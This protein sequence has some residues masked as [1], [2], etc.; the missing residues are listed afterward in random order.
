MD[1]CCALC[2]GSRGVLSSTSDRGSR[3][4]ILN[5]KS[6]AAL[7]SLTLVASILTIIQAV[8][9]GAAAPASVASLLP[10]DSHSESSQMSDAFDGVTTLPGAHFTALADSSATQVAWYACAV[11]SGSESSIPTGCTLLGTDETGIQTEGDG[12]EGYDL[13]KDFTAAQQGN[14]DVVAQACVGSPAADG[15]D[16]GSVPDNC[17]QD[18]ESGIRFDDGDTGGR[19]FVTGEAVATCEEGACG[20]PPAYVTPFA[21]GEVTYNATGGAAVYT[22][23]DAAKISACFDVGFDS[24]SDVLTCDV[25]AT[26]ALFPFETTDTYKR[27]AAFVDFPDNQTWALIMYVTSATYGC[28]GSDLAPDDPK[29]DATNACVIGVR[30]GRSTSADPAVAIG[31]FLVGDRTCKDE[32]DLNARVASEQDEYEV[33]QAGDTRDAVGCLEKPAKDEYRGDR[34]A[35]WES[36]GPGEITACTGTLS[37]SDSDGA[38]DRCVLAAGA[39]DLT[40]GASIGNSSSESGEQVLTFCDDPEGDGCAGATVFDTVTA[41]WLGEGQVTQCSDGIDND[42]D[43][44]V[45]LADAGCT[46]LLDDSEDSD[47]PVD[48]ASTISAKF[49]RGA[50]KGKVG[51]DDPACVAGRKVVV[52]KGTRKVGSST[53]KDSGAYSVKIG[54]KKG[55][56]SATVKPST[57]NG[58]TVNCLQKK[59]R[60]VKVG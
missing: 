10:N 39:A 12:D 60:I 41:V 17:V 28:E 55:R 30:Y 3:G 40:Y 37:D 18:V 49:R 5:R 45:D 20:A 2:L 4:G 51:S 13:L 9:A 57:A 34:Q 24:S 48:A 46:D 22:S 19:E 21:N 27:G 56:F 44:D 54:R 53:T 23:L 26:N 47:Q 29:I 58:G 36:S 15:A 11:G 50:I 38:N 7:M 31:S 43:G 42:G 33:L 59:S 1:F 16:A 14:W 6:L 52:K 8:P 32:G 35:T 25:Y